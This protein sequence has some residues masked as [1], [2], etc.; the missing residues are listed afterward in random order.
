MTTGCTG[1]TIVSKNSF[2]ERLNSD[3]VNFNTEYCEWSDV[4]WFYFAY[5][6]DNNLHLYCLYMFN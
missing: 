4:L 3:K 2:I 1:F 6:P 5:F